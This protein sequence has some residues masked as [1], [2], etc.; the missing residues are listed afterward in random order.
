MNKI[1]Q[2][3]FNNHSLLTGSKLFLIPESFFSA[4]ALMRITG[5]HSMNILGFLFFLLCMVFYATAA[6]EAVTA[7]PESAKK[8][9][10]LS[11]L[12]SA[13][14]TLFY[15]LGSYKAILQD[16]NNVLFQGILLSVTAIGLLILFYKVVFYL[17][18]LL[19]RTF[20]PEGKKKHK[21]IPY[22]PFL[23][24]FLCLLCRLPYFLYSYPGILTPDSINQFEQVL[25]M[26]PFSNHH[27]WIHT[28]TISLF[29][30]LGT[31]FTASANHAFAF[32]T[33]FQIC[34]MAFAAA[35][36][37]W[38]L[39]KYTHCL[40]LLWSVILFYALMPYHNVMAVCI[41]KDVLFSGSLLIFC[42]SLLYLLKPVE[43]KTNLFVLFLYFLSGI[44]VCLYRSN[45]WYAFLLTLPFLL[46][47]FREH[48]KR[49]LPLH[50]LILAVVFIVKGPVME[51]YDVTQPDFVESI[52]VP[53]QQVC[54]VLVEEKEL[55]PKQET[56]INNVI[57]TTYIKELYVGY[58]ADNM[59]ELVRAGHPE[60][61]AA[62]KGDYFKLWLELGLKY[63][64]TYLDAYTEQTFG[65]YS[66]AAVYNVAETEGIIPN[67][68][69]L[70][71]TPLIGGRIIIK[72]REVLNK[73]YTI[74][75]L[76]GALWSMG[77]LFWM[78]LL[79]L[80][81]TLGRSPKATSFTDI[82]KEI[83]LW[84]PNLAVIGTLLLATPVA[85][86]FRYAYNLAYCLPLYMAV[87]LLTQ[88]RK[89]PPQ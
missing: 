72:L 30:H 57:D 10:W 58:F 71:A 41:W 42:A 54:R 76:Y 45:G 61:L 23:C 8:Q 56:L 7:F 21:I 87:C 35:F 40:P 77:S 65:F 60:F 44:L 27:P 39:T 11:F 74:I 1:N 3:R 69:G 66:P 64:K 83:T 4:W 59:K 24:F 6:R 85:T 88:D 55:S 33:I 79:S 16:L 89:T 80:F 34:F 70:S 29:Y 62:H 17:M 13:L 14:F 63:P 51:H 38:I 37:I 25:G 49:M 31:F 73:L 50:L 19:R 5:L 53:L 47:A 52:S 9:Q 28:L 32:Y 18:C 81:L 46:V 12:A 36:L 78:T 68:T 43:E 84:I 22:L 86:E 20:L 48:Y 2:S 67:D 26:Q 15:L 75:P 82:L